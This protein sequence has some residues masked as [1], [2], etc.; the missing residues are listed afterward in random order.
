MHAEKKKKHVLITCYDQ[1]IDPIVLQIIHDIRSEG[2]LL[3][4]KD[5]VRIPGGVHLLAGKSDCR[6]TFYELLTSYRDIAKTDVFHFFPHTNCQY[7]GIHFQEKIGDGNRSDLRFHLRSAEKLLVGV[8]EHFLDASQE[9]P[10]LD[11]RIILTTDQRIV[12]IEEAHAILPHVPDHEHGVHCQQV[13]RI[14][15][16]YDDIALRV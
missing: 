10:I 5:I 12:S 3:A 16:I 2:G 4:G 14:P 15:H 11:A 7:C 1:R 13:H 6:K 9:S 8:M